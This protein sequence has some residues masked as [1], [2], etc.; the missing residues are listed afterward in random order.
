M[1]KVYCIGTNIVSPLGVTTQENF[2]AILQGKSG[3]NKHSQHPISVKDFCASIF[4]N[5][6]LQIETYSFFESLLIHSIQDLLYQSQIKI[7]AK[8]GLIIS[9]TKGNISFLEE[10][11]SSE[12][13]KSISLYDAA[14]KV[15]NYFQIQNKPIIISHACISGVVAI[16]TGKRLIENNKYDD[17][18]IVGADTI[19]KFILSGFQSF[20]AVSEHLCK[21]FDAAREGINLGEAAAGM[22]LSKQSHLTKIKIIG[23][24]VSNDANHISGPSR[25][26]AEL[27]QAIENAIFEAGIHK[28]EI[29]FISAHGTATIFNDDMESNAFTLSSLQKIPVNSL[30]GYLGHTLG[31]AGILE[32]VVSIA[33]LQN[34]TIIA[35]K[36]FKNLGTAQPINICSTT[37]EKPLHTCLKTASGFGGCNAAIIIQK[38]KS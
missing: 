3:V 15:A 1:S 34:N 31:A 9:S 32:S 20:H 16:I 28:N 21:P 4:K 38:E 18:I 22:V 26:G 11:S 13:K 30:K 23:G 14:Q 19:T 17:I 29:D 25:T 33:S 2:Q 27:H 12:V 35:T 8:T 36:G 5:K 10:T 24:A 6:N 37:I 7:S